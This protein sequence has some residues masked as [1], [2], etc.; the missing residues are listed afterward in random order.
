MQ[1]AATPPPAPPPP[2]R[3]RLS[4]KFLLTVVVLLILAFLGGYI[5]P[6]LQARQVE[7]TL[8]AAE[9]DLQLA[10]LHRQLGL[11]ALE[12][13]RMN[14]ASAAQAAS[15]FFDGARRLADANAFPNQPRTQMAIGAYAAARDMV[16]GQLATGDPQGAQKLSGRFFAMDGVIERRQ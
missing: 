8:A 6:K 1:P 4:G 14:Y 5:P 13:Q 9:V 16:M 11:A 10:T 12:A 15:R 7:K 3:R 2:T